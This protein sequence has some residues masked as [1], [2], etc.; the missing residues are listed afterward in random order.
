MDEPTEA[1]VDRAAR[2]PEETGGSESRSVDRSAVGSPAVGSPAVEDAEELRRSWLVATFLLAGLALLATTLGGAPTVLTSLTLRLSSGGSLEE[3]ALATHVRYSEPFELDAAQAVR[4]SVAGEGALL[5]SL[6]A[7]DSS[8][9]VRELEL[10]G[11]ATGVFGR[12]AAGRYVLRAVGEGRGEA[13]IEARAGGFSWPLTASAA[14]LVVA[15]AIS[16][17]WRA[18]RRRRVDAVSP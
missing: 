15:P 13:R 4:V 3:D 12:V 6:V 11:D 1:R 9:A 16:R 5:V 8:E 2:A 10:D 14:L 17:S 18:R 7:L